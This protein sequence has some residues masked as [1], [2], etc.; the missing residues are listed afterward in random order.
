MNFDNNVNIN[1]TVFI[2]L[3]QKNPYIFSP[4]SCISPAS[5]LNEVAIIRIAP[6]RRSLYIHA[7]FVLC[8]LTHFS[9]IFH[10]YNPWKSGFLTFLGGIEMEHWTKMV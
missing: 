2:I 10:F 6:K 8:C 7:S 5:I 9:Q 3:S 1:I 4:C